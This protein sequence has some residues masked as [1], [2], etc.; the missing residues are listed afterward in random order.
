MNIKSIKRCRNLFKKDPSLFNNTRLG[1]PDTPHQPPTSHLTHH[2]S[3]TINLKFQVGFMYD[4]K[5][6]V[7]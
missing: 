4:N 1:I 7:S 2:I 3:T 5:F 6:I